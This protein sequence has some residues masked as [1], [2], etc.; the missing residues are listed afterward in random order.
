MSLVYVV[1]N[2]SAEGNTRT[3]SISV[4]DSRNF[5]LLNLRDYPI[6]IIY[7]LEVVDSSKL[8][9]ELEKEIKKR[10]NDLLPSHKDNPS[11]TPGFK[12]IRYV[13]D[14]DVEDQILGVY[15]DVMTNLT[16]K[17]DRLRV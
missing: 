2:T 5:T 4:S 17:S 13:V 3:A 16:K 14:A 8:I 15:R 7:A 9:D 6:E 11:R 10:L 1:F 12:Q